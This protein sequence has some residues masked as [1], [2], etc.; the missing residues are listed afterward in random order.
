MELKMKKDTTYLVMKVHTAYAVLLDNSGRYIKA[1]NKGYQTGDTVRDITPLIYPSDRAENRRKLIRLAAGLAAC[2]CLGAFGVYEYQ[3]LYVP[4][5]TMQMQINPLIEMTLSRSGRVLDLK[6]LNADG[7]VLAES[8][9]YKGETAEKTA[10]GL[11]DL[12]VQMEYLKDGGQIGILADSESSKW[13][14]QTEHS[15]AG[16]LDEHLR[17]E[18]VTVEILTGTI[19]LDTEDGQFL[20]DPQSVTIPIPGAQDEEPA[21]PEQPVQESPAPSTP[22]QPQQPAAPSGGSGDSGYNAEG[23]SGY[24]S[25]GNSGYGTSGDSGYS[26]DD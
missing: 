19:D 13:T 10:S 4:Y 12:A 17:S 23:D 6:G 26:G 1:A 15:V 2:V 21:E 22:V 24:S 9:D 8:Y 25:E 20:Q 7:E 11:A 14:S 5:G 16:A 18:S 3:Y